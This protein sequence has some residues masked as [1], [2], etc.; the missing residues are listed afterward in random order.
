MQQ[1]SAGLSFMVVDEASSCIAAD[2]THPCRLQQVTELLLFDNM[3]ESLPA[4]LFEMSSLEMLN[5]DRNHLM[6]IPSTVRI[7]TFPEIG[8][9]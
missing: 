6:E 4:S 8:V 3:L 7:D 1:I 2:P 5:V 9:I